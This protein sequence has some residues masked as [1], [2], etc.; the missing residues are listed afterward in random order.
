MKLKNMINP[1][2]TVK[3]GESFEDAV[4]RTI[5]DKNGHINRLYATVIGQRGLIAA[6]LIIIVLLL[7]AVMGSS[8]QPY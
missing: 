2:V 7:M 8:E 6:L 1:T 5:G 3:P 4:H